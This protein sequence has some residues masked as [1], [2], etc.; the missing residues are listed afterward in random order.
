MKKF[1]APD[2]TADSAPYWQALK[3]HVLQLQQCAACAGFRFP[4]LPSCP[5]CGAL[6]GQWVETSLHG[7]LCS[8]TEIFHPLDPRLKDEVPFVL[9]LVDLDAGPRVSARLV[10]ADPQALRIGMRV[11]ARF[12]DLDDELTILNFEPAAADALDAPPSTTTTTRRPA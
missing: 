4:P 8:W 11:T 6:G 2:I 5:K 3:R 7:R 9:V 1:L 12:D 10:G